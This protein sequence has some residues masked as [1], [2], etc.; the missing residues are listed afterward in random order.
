M[1]NS[2]ALIRCSNT[3][4]NLT[5]RYEATTEEELHRIENEFNNLINKLK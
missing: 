3:G 5:V 1:T 2:W 4:P